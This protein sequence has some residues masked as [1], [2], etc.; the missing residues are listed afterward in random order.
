MRF[1]QTQATAATCQMI[2]EFE[3][4]LSGVLMERICRVMANDVLLLRIPPRLPHQF[5]RD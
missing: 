5:P 4:E 3:G 1:T 2:R